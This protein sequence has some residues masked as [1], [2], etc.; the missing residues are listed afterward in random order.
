MPRSTPADIFKRA[1]NG[2]PNVVTPTV[3]FYG[4]RGEQVYELSFGEML[5]E[6]VFGVTVLDQDG[7]PRHDLST[8]F[9]IRQDAEAYIKAGF[10]KAS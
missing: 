3:L 2:S 10:Q 4:R 8:C 5:K 6:Q 9:F 1:F 7:T